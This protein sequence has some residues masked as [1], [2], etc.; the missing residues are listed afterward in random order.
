MILKALKIV[1]VVEKFAP[2][3]INC[4][5]IPTSVANTMIISKMFH[6]N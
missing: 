6:A 2:K 4:S 5:T 1:M 3:F